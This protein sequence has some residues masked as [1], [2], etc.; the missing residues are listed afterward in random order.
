MRLEELRSRSP[1]TLWPAEWVS[2]M[3]ALPEGVTFENPIFRY[4]GFL[5]LWLPVYEAT[6]EVES[7]D[8]GAQFL[9]SISAEGFINV[10]PRKDGGGAGSDEFRSVRRAVASTVEIWR[11]VRADIG[12]DGK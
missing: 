9:T 6:C 8:T 4:D 11:A 5:L 12:V 10:L 7:V 2:R 1:E 3:P